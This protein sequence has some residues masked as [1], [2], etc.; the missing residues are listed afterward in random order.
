MRPCASPRAS[1]PR[2]KESHQF[3]ANLPLPRPYGRPCHPIFGYTPHMRFQPLVPSVHV[4][5][6]KSFPF[7]AISPHSA[8]PRHKTANSYRR[9]T[10]P[11]RKDNRLRQKTASHRHKTDRL[12]HKTER[13]RHKTER[14]RHKIGRL[15]HEIAS[16]H[17]TIAQVRPKSFENVRAQN[18]ISRM[19]TCV[20]TRAAQQ[21]PRKIPCIMQC[22]CSPSLI[23]GEGAG[24]WGFCPQ[25]KQG[26]AGGSPSQAPD[27][28]SA[29]A[30]LTRN[31]SGA[32]ASATSAPAPAC[33]PRACPIIVAGG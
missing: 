13:L 11:H 8:I 15:R 4:M 19:T 2:P 6:K 10:E 3:R 5:A 17:H 29:L 26:R 18:G 25:R 9:E 1:Q 28:Q 16:H 33:Q 30:W 32:T 7:L 31:L 22:F 21:R 14:L 20:D 12:R 27:R 23:L 24:G